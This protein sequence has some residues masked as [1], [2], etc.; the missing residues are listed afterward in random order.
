MEP[1]EGVA[2]IQGDFRE[3]DVLAQLQA[4]LAADQSHPKIDLVVSDMAP[5]LSGIE[6]ADAA[7]ISHLVELAVDFAVHQLKPGGALVVKLFHGSGY[8]ELARLFK[9]HFQVVKKIKPKA[10]RPQSSETFLVGLGLKSV[11]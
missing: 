10:S 6:S 11:V 1:I 9:T 7:R 5:N 2:F 3:A 4:L 8:E